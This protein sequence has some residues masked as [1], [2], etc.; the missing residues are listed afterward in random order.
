M[1]KIAVTGAHGRLGSELVRQGAIPIISDICQYEE[2]YEEIQHI[3][4]DVIV[5]CAA[6]T[7]PRWCEEHPKETLAI[8]YHGAV[9]IRKIFKKWLIQIS[10]DWVFDGTSGPYSETAKPCPLNTYGWS[11]WG[12][13][14]MLSAY[15]DCPST[16]V[17][18]TSLYDTVSTNFVTQVIKDLGQDK[19]FFSIPDLCGN[20]TYIPHLVVALQ[21]LITRKIDFVH[22][23]NLAGTTWISR[24]TFAL[25]IAQKFVPENLSLIKSGCPPELYANMKYPPKAGFNLTLAKKLSIPLHSLDEGLEAFHVALA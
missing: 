18:V 25:R 14:I 19:E 5:N 13:E 16:I 12:A 23:I 4:P 21:D 10:T 17:R 6:K 9:N 11:K 15:A 24:H 3:N 8:N 22:R 20:P 2:L 1:T 7:K